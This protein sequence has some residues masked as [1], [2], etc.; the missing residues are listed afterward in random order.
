VTAAGGDGLVIVRRLK[1]IVGSARDVAGPT[2]HSRRLL[3]AEDGLRFS[4]HDTVLHAGSETLI[5]YRHHVEAVYC[6]EGRGELETLD[7]GI[8]YQIQPGTMYALD[9][10]ERH[11]L[12]A[13]TDLRVLC[14]F[15]P[16]LTGS[17]VHDQD[18]TYPPPETVA[19]LANSAAS[20]R[21]ETG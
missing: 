20:P 12:R 7:G 6:I 8:V 5:W 11:L 2:F 21:P 16:A 13:H 10:H 3:L 9:G 19:P 18:G 14:V 1:E 4:L 17:E 15:D